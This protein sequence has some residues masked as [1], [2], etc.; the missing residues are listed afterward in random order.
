MHPAFPKFIS[1]LK[2]NSKGII[3][4]VGCGVGRHL[5]PITQQGYKGIGI[6]VSQTALIKAKKQSATSTNT[7][8]TGLIQASMTHLPLNSEK[9]AGILCTN[10]VHH[11]MPSKIRQ[12]VADFHRILK[13]G[14]GGLVTILSDRDFKFGRGEQ[15]AEKTFKAETGIEAGVVHTFFNRREIR[16]LLENFRIIS[17][18]HRS[19]EFSSGKS[20]HWNV[21]VIK[22]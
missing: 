12:A 2:R 22:Q 18:K 16:L 20:C 21:T 5:T 7:T 6:D 10:V 15:L 9:V 19:A 3:V 4:D 1:W 8:N 13:R 17:L 11:D 14:G